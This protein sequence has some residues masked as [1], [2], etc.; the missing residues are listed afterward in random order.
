MLV[1]SVGF[2]RSDKLRYKGADAKR[3]DDHNNRPDDE[4]DQR[5]RP[6][7]VSHSANPATQSVHGE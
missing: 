3:A 1:K 4:E 6:Y 7:Y 2:R 5:K